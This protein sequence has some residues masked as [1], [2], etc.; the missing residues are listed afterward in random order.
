M[1]A[2]HD[3]Y[4]RPLRADADPVKLIEREFG[5]RFSRGTNFDGWW[6]PAGRDVVDYFSEHDLEDNL[7]IPYASHPLIFAV[8]DLD[9]DKEREYRIAKDRIFDL[10]VRTGDYSCFILFNTIQALDRHVIEQ[11]TA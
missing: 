11:P 1:S 10:L 7:G 9:G 4:V 3:V 2:Y 5:A 6:L 8:R